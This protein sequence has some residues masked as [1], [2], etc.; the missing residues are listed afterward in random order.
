MFHLYYAVLAGI[1]SIVTIQKWH[2]G[3]TL[4]YF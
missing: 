4:L 2:S 1:L 3:I